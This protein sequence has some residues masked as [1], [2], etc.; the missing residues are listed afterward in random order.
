MVDR[1]DRLARYAI[2]SFEFG[3][4]EEADNLPTDEVT[5]YVEVVDCLGETHR[6]E[7]QGG[8]GILEAADVA[9][10]RAR[11]AWWTRCRDLLEQTLPKARRASIPVNVRIVGPA[12]REL[13]DDL[14]AQPVGRD[15]MPGGK[16]GHLFTI[17]G[18]ERLLA[19]AHQ[20]ATR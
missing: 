15:L 6:I 13:P 4:P 14:P 20:E 9:L 18:A 7:R 17:E 19:R 3:Y 5:F 10:A 16:V 8:A 12:D 1:V 11:R 2:G